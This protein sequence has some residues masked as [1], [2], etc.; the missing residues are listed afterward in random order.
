MFISPL[1]YGGHTRQQITL[2][3]DKSP[4]PYLTWTAVC[5]CFQVKSCK[6]FICEQAKLD[7][8]CSNS[9]GS[10]FLWSADFE[11]PPVTLQS[12]TACPENPSLTSCLFSQ[13]GLALFLLEA[14]PSILSGSSDTGCGASGEAADEKASMRALICVAVPALAFASLTP[15]HLVYMSQLAVLNHS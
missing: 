10:N 12:W 9:N 7:A 15:Q 13:S 8:V 14:H 6:R 5:F 4:E 2:D 3:P 1:M 11:L